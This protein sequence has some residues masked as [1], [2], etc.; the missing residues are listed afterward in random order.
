M[1]GR[2]PPLL[3]AAG[4]AGAAGAVPGAPPLGGR[5]LGAV[6]LIAGGAVGA[7]IIALPVKTFGAGFG[8]S[9]AVLCLAFAYMTAAALLL[10]ELS[11]AKPGANLSA[12]ALEAL[13]G[14][15]RGLCVGLYYLIYLAT[16]TAYVAES[17]HFLAALLRENLDFAVP[18][19]LLSALFTAWLSL[20]VCA[21]TK[22]TEAV[23]RACLLVALMA[24]ALLLAWGLGGLQVDRLERGS[25]AEAGPTLPLCVVA[26]TYHNLVPSL[27]GYLGSPRLA[28]RAVA[29]GG[30]V[31]LVMYVLW[32]AVILGSLPPDSRVGSAQEVVSLLQDWLGTRAGAVVQLFSLFSIATSFLG[33]GL[34]CLDFMRDLLFGGGGGGAGGGA[35]ASRWGA[36]E[37]R[38]LALSS[39]VLPALALG[40]L[41]PGAFL[42][43]LD[44]SGTLR[45][46][47]FAVLPVLM[48]WRL[49]YRHHLE[50]WLPGG[51]PLLAAMLA[52]AAGVIG[53][54]LRAKL[55]IACSAA[56]AV[57]FS[58]AIAGGAL[59]H[60]SYF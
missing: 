57:G 50:P 59:L 42:V 8:P 48:V 26:F 32:E 16:L 36:G 17:G 35:G 30:S 41:W 39:M 49:R 9:S 58:L 31:P 13:G 33:V 23:N 47:L 53:L 52:V 12:M 46:L 5:L 38:I 28:A 24:Y 55:G 34:G 45:L 14:K 18:S 11:A 15:G 3:G 6:A 56:Q 54:E 21:G 40:L 37:Q 7:G 44:Y 19:A 60:L 2:E 10:V 43:A 1:P 27:V 25:W 29:L 22:E 51:R 20:V 4:A